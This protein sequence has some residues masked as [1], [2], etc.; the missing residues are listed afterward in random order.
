MTASMQKP[1]FLHISRIRPSDGK[2]MWDYYD[3]DRCPVSWRF[4]DNSIELVF[5]REVQVL[6]YLTF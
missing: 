3:R 1:A 5:K 4:D 6:R 2:I